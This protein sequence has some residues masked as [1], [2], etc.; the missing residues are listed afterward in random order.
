MSTDGFRDVKVEVVDDDGQVKY[1]FGL[2]F[3]HESEVLKS[4]ASVKLA[5]ERLE[6]KTVK[7]RHTPKLIDISNVRN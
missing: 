5:I 7:I 1:A 4:V 3:V 2:S 6:Q